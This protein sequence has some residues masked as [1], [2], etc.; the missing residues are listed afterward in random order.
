MALERGRHF[1]S[2]T[3][4]FWLFSQALADEIDYLPPKSFVPCELMCG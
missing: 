2:A 1:I 4:E 3:R